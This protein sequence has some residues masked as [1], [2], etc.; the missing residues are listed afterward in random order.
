VSGY[1]HIHLAF[2]TLN[3]DFSVNVSSMGINLDLFAS[4]SSPKRI[5]SLEVGL[6]QLIPAHMISS[7]KPSVVKI[8]EKRL[9]QT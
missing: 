4:I 7:G 6:S 5:L 8:I 9:L 2:A 3:S 1:T